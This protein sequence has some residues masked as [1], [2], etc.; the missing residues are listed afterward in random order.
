MASAGR[1]AQAFYAE[2]SRATTALILSCIGLFCCGLPALF[3]IYIGRQ[4]Q[5][6]IRAGLRDPSK[7][8]MATAAVV[9]GAAVAALWVV[10][11]GFA[12]LGLAVGAGS[13]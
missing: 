9:I 12:V 1:G 13:N 4:E 8:G 10:A 5:K 3:G 11:G 7:E 6:G 2:S